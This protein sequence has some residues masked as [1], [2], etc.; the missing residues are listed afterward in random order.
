MSKVSVLTAYISI[1]KFDVICISETFLSSDT[2]FDNDSLIIEGYNIVRSDHPSNSRWG[3]VF[4]YYKQSLALMHRLSGISRLK[5][6]QFH[7]FILIPDIFDQFVDNLQLTLDEVA[8][9]SHFLIAFFGDFEVKSE[10][11][12]KHDKT[13]YDYEG[14]KIDA[15]RQNSD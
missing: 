4:I 10:N 12:Y 8:N 3:G 13:S 1:H 5:T 14:S 11:W 7:F 15:L 6:I 9:R 2:T